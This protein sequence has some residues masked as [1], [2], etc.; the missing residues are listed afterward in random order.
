MFFFESNS[1]AYVS[2]DTSCKQHIK[3]NEW[4]CK[5]LWSIFVICNNCGSF[6][7]NKQRIEKFMQTGDFI[8]KNE[9]V[10]AC[11]QHDMAYGKTKDLVKKNSI[12]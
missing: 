6:T 5:N 4:N 2:K 12:R 7:K 9:L 8:Y 11:F 10:K 1:I 3:M